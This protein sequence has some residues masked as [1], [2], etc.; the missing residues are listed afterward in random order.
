[1]KRLAL[2]IGSALV[3]LLALAGPASA[4][5]TVSSQDAAPGG[6]AM[7]T[8]RVPTESDTAST[9]KLEVHF[10]QNVGSARVQP[11]PGWSY[12]IGKSGDTV[13]TITWTAT[14]GGIKPNEF[15]QFQVSVGPLPQTDQ[16]SF[17]AIQTYS[18]GSVVSWNETPAP[19]STTEPD[20]PSP[21]L[22]L[23][24]TPTA[25]PAAKSTSSTGP[26]TLSIVALALA[27]AALSLT[28]IGRAKAR[29]ES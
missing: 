21:T 23:T 17:P 10:P 15:S 13:S 14:A 11:V 18:D 4:H 7:L 5:V 6:Y 12:T 20:H 3:A 26:Y 29:K 25:A 19:G 28:V 2:L 8:F 22:S 16:L 9:T 24:K 1:M 27:A